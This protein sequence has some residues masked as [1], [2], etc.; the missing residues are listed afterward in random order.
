MTPELQETLGNVGKRGYTKKLQKD[1]RKNAKLTSSHMRE[2]PDKIQTKTNV[3]AMSARDF[4]LN[5]SKSTIHK[6]R[7]T[8]WFELALST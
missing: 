3:V 5:I 6:T 1:R 7:Q 8:S 4:E 2:V